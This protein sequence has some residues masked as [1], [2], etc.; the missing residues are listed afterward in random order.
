M[1]AGIG[2]VLALLVCFGCILATVMPT[3]GFFASALFHPTSTPFSVSSSTANQL[4]AVRQT[5]N[6][7]IVLNGPEV[8]N[9]DTHGN[10]YVG[11]N[12]DGTISIFNPSGDLT[13]SIQWVDKNLNDS[14][15]NGMAVAPDGTI[16]VSYAGDIHRINPD[17]SQTLLP[18]D[19]N[20]TLTGYLRGIVMLKDGSLLA[21]DDSGNILR[22]GTD[23]DVS[24]VVR[25]PFEAY[26][27]DSD[28]Q[29]ILASDASGNIYALGMTTW[30]IIKL[31][32][33][34]SF[35]SQ[36]GGRTHNHVRNDPG[37]QLG[38]DVPGLD[39]GYFFFP[40]ALAI[41]PYGRIFVGDGTGYV[42]IFDKDETYLNSFDVPDDINSLTFDPSGY[43]FMTT[44]T[45]QLLKIEVQAP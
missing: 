37:E 33:D 8:V 1:I 45:P 22:F 5:Q 12:A 4:M 3:A 31:A 16:Y 15:L 7:V 10:I 39:P 14:S 18:Y 11:N 42:Q 25:T 2:L 17:G 35:I 23:G 29:L 32:P 24:V 36:F 41:D 28:L 26:L 13:R 44:D 21:T 6:G 27:D 9:L 34:G 38:I 30:Q 20:T 40:S 43:L 19:E